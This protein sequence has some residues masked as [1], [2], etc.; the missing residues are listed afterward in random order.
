[1]KLIKINNKEDNNEEIR[2]IDNIEQ[3]DIIVNKKKK[4]KTNNINNKEF[5]DLYK[6]IKYLEYKKD[7]KN[8]KYSLNRLNST[9]RASYNAQ[10]VIVK[11]ELPQKQNIKKKIKHFI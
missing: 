6:L 8:F 3:S 7:G 2:E 5:N 4:L 10:I 9:L 1:M 11:E